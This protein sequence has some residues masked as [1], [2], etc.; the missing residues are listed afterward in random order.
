MLPVGR[1][2]LKTPRDPWRF[3]LGL[4]PEGV[5]VF[6]AAI[7]LAAQTVVVSPGQLTAFTLQRPDTASATR[8]VVS[9]SGMPFSQAVRV[10]TVRTPGNRWDI[11]LNRPLSSVFAANDVLAGEVWL[12]RLDGTNASA[13]V[14]GVFERSGTPYTQSLT[15]LWLASGTNWTRFRFAFRCVEAYA[16]TTADRAQFNLRLGFPPQTVEIGGLA[17]TNFGLT[18]PLA[19]FPND[20]N[21]SGREPEAPW[22]AAAAERIERLRKAD[23]AVEVLDADGF[24]VPGAEVRVR[25]QRHA[26]HWGSAVDG[27]RLLGSF[28][29]VSDRGRY[30][31][32]ITNWFNKVVLEND[33]KWPSWESTTPN[34]RTALAALDWLQARGIPC[35]GHNL[36]WPGTNYLPSRVRSSLASRNAALVRQQI[37][38]HFT[39]VLGAVRGRLVDWDVMNE[40]THE[41]AVQDL[42]GD[43]EMI[44]WMQ[45]ARNLDP[46]A[47]LFVNEYENLEVAGTGS[48]A[49]GR[50][51]DA[52]RFLKSR[53]APLDG[54]GLQGHFGGFLPAPEDVYAQ[55][56]AFAEF[57]L[58]IQVTEFDVAVGDE[59]AQADYVRDLTTV[60]FSH[61]AVTDFLMWGFWAGQ[62]WK[63][64]AALFRSDWSL[65]PAGVAWSNLVF[66]EW[67]TDVAV[68]TDR[69]GRAAFRGF[70]GRYS[71]EVRVGNNVVGTALAEPVEGVLRVPRV[72]LERPRLEAVRA[73][74]GGLEFTWP[75]APLGYRIESSVDLAGGRWDPIAKAPLLEGGLWRLEIPPES[76]TRFYRLVR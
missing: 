48:A 4:V 24:P 53:G 13:L 54:I 36:I 31:A 73:A 41:R 35:R 69:S 3:L 32:V 42:L 46:A 57:G 30:Q 39:N 72:T 11:Q 49:P 38:Q 2:L 21:Y 76:G 18:R 47:K 37:D 43:D 55:L 40:I 60:A 50:F 62:H 29:T 45:L 70:R 19:D 52:L 71:I 20:V 1:V 26:F 17:L 33:L 74:S 65:R 66:R 63:P 28:G 68:R 9:V 64:E 22:R 7:S 5:A 25:L 23:H 10:Q 8:T 61:P 15:R 67:T 12:R 59:A 56:D 44:R 58:P 14:E 16:G 6:L 34:G 75:E 51:L 27:G